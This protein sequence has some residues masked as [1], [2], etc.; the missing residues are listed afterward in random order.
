MFFP[1]KQL[2]KVYKKDPD[3]GEVY[4]NVRN[5]DPEVS[6]PLSPFFF[7][8]VKIF[9]RAKCSSVLVHSGGGGGGEEESTV[10]LVYLY[11]VIL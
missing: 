9:V 1:P 8:C 6:L 2:D 3:K 11:P 5:P 10:N 7:S 4:L